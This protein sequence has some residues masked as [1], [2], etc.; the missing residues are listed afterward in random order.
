MMQKVL[1]VIIFSEER[2]SDEKP[3]S[4]KYNVYLSPIT[5]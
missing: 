4:Y 3:D 1:I 2:V 5:I